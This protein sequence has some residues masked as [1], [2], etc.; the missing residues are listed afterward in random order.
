M[1]EILPES[2]CPIQSWVSQASACV[3]HYAQGLLRIDAV[4]PDILRVRF[5]PSGRLAPPRSWS[6]VLDLPPAGLSVT[7]ENLVVKMSTDS[8]GATLD[9]QCGLLQFLT[10]DGEGFAA[11][12]SPPSWREVAL[13]E[14]GMEH[15]PEPELP[16]GDSRIGV[17]LQKR[18][19]PDEGY[20]G[21]GQRTG[22]LD[23]RRRRLTNWTIDRS[24]PG[25]SRGDDNMYQTHPMFMAARPGLAWGLFL[26]STWYSAFDVGAQD[27]DILSIVTLGG[28]LDYFV[29]AGPTPAAVVEQLTRLTGRPMLPP[30]WAMGYHQSRWSYGTDEDVRGIARSFRDHWIPLDAIHLD[31]DYMDGYRVFTWDKDRFPKPSETIA[32]LHE[33]HVRVVTIV[34]PGVKKDPE[35]G[36]ATFESGL[37]G[38]HFIQHADGEP[39]SGWVWPDESLFPDFCRSA[40]RLWWGEQHADLVELGIDGIWCDMNE[41]AIVDRPFRELGVCEQPMPLSLTQGDDGE[42]LHAETH[43]LYGQLMAQAT[44]EALERL[45]PERRP[46]VLTRSGFVGVQRWAATW[47][48][49]NN[50]WWEHLEMSLPQLASMGLCGSPHVGVDIGGFYQHSHAELYARW[51]EL[52]TFYPFMRSHAHCD[53]RAQEP[54]SFGPEIETIARSAIELRYRL[55]PYLYT[56]AH[57]AHRHGAPL[58]RPLLY[59]FPDAA[60][61]HQIHDQVMVGPQLMIA[62]IFH[63]GV[64][65]RLVELPPGHTW[66][67][68][69]TGVPI[70][71]DHLVAD[72]P[73]GGLPILVRGGSILTLGNVRPST[74]EPLSELTLDVYPDHHNSGTWTLIEDDG[75]SF[76]YQDGML[77]ETQMWI[78]PGS[79][80]TELS[81]AARQGDFVPPQRR[82]TIRLHLPQPPASVL[83]DGSEATDW[84]WDESRH[85]L[86]LGLDDDGQEHH[87]APRF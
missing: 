7:E 67:D 68:F 82:M 48:G 50:A 24:S 52:G 64:R 5:A 53:S 36:Y 21:F 35:S 30:L 31:I 72:A 32:A 10:P 75:E 33:D 84:T 51:I 20:F 6:P 81:I 55:L 13:E 47:M 9:L 43:N 14:T 27:E 87:I 66:Y 4:A 54:W 28:E 19:T 49:D 61:L 39:F 41:P 40:T 85:A 70:D 45:R 83:L 42:G 16:Q 17:F 8:I 56:L 74:A 11:D 78:A 59:D 46:W 23:R 71:S 3:A 73:L 37:A 25:H 76:A 65:R 62:A 69:R 18:M 29:F 86:V 38:G 1:D 15:M 60:H 80:G 2:P 22:Q 58:L 12:L 79:Q 44:W 57:L 63:P 26:N 77:C 34:D